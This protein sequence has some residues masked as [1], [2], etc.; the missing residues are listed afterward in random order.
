MSEFH[1]KQLRPLRDFVVV[2]PLVDIR[3]GLIEVV[4]MDGRWRRGEVLAV[5]P[6]K[7][8]RDGVQRPWGTRVGEVVQFADVLTYPEFDTGI[9][10]VLLIQEADICG[11]EQISDEQADAILI[12]HEAI[13]SF[14][15]KHAETGAHFKAR[16]ERVA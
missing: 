15:E 3:E 6:G 10:R 8:S 14:V 2:R 4:R 11:I 7:R 1:V 13:D 12:L 9:E 5:G 16:M